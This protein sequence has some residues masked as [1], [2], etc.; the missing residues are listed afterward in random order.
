MLLGS[1]LCWTN[2]QRQMSRLVREWTVGCRLAGAG[3]RA[4]PRVQVLA[5]RSYK[6]LPKSLQLSALDLALRSG[7][8][9]KEVGLEAA[10]C[11]L[12]LP[13]P[14]ADAG[15]V[16]GMW[17][18]DLPLS[19]SA[20]I[21]VSLPPHYHC[22]GSSAGAQAVHC[23]GPGYCAIGKWS[24]GP[25]GQM[26][27]EQ[28]RGVE[29]LRLAKE[30]GAAGSPLGSTYLASGGQPLELQGQRPRLAKSHVLECIVPSASSLKR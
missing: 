22:Q 9:L 6:R 14:W 26:W 11:V 20:V 12:L 18:V 21:I 1:R 29:I 30:G 16:P 3:E 27:G 5:L 7:C 8:S 23:W 2:M 25:T 19:L 17:P 13:W 4:G 24:L 28:S 10:A 15:S